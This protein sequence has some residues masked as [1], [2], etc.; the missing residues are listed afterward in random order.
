MKAL[1]PRSKMTGLF[2]Q[3]SIENRWNVEAVFPPEIFRI[4]SD[5]FRSVT[6]GRHRKLT[7]IHREKSNKFLVGILLSLP[8]IYSA[9][10]QDL[11]AVIFDLGHDSKLFF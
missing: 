9:F 11:V 5:D 1:F 3:E 6:A 8:A 4:F 10:L 7:E 2:R